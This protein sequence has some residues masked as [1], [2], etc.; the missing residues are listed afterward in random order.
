LFLEQSEHLKTV[1]SP[2]G[3]AEASSTDFM[4]IEQVA[5][6]PAAWNLKRSASDGRDERLSRTFCT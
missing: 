3:L 6:R 5:S 4:E 2:M 1:A